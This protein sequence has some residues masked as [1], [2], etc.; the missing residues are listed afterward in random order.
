[1][2]SPILSLLHV[3]DQDFV[4]T[5]IMSFAALARTRKLGSFGS[6]ISKNKH[7]SLRW[8]EKEVNVEIQADKE[9]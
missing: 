5:W 6:T 2:V 9:V 1:M 8:G 4:E 7:P 3:E